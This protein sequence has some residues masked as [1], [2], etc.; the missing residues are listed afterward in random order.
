MST[1]RRTFLASG[2]AAGAATPLLRQR[3]WLSALAGRPGPSDAVLVVVQVRGGWDQLNL[4][5]EVDH[6]VYKAAR[7]AIGLPKAKVL[8]LQGGALHY[9]HPAAQAFKDLYDR[10]DLAV[11]ENVGY[12][13]PNLSHFASEKKWYAADPSISVFGQGWLSKYLV[14]GYTGSFPI[15]A[16]NILSS[17][18]PA[19][20]GSRVPVFTRVS[21]FQFVFDGSTWA[22]T[23]NA[24]QLATL[25]GNAQALRAGAGPALM[26]IAGG[27]ADAVADSAMLQSVGASYA[28]KATYPSSTLSSH[29]QIAARYITGG[30]QTRIYYASTGGFDTHANQ[31]ASGSPELGTYATRIGDVTSSVKAFLDDI[32]AHAQEKRVVVL[33]F[34]EFGRRL[35]E[36]GSIGTDHGHGNISF[37]AGDPVNGGRYGKPPDLSKATTPYH[38]YYV[39]FDASS[40][41][42]RSIYASLIDKWFNVPHAT[43]LGANYPLLGFL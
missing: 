29:L 33:L 35:G 11:I 19:F 13:Q 23:D 15:P 7:P 30:L 12:P 42:F 26:H 37:V 2:L 39:P 14:H 24:L 21:D 41:D 43:V 5:A 32:K 25:E 27:T 28:P 20:Q 1:T 17:Q 4:L 40:T 34:S 38:N 22:R 31:V 16:I 36:N 3:N 9:W 6:P 18:S 8:P 10:G